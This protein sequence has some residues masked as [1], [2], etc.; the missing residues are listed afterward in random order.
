M[1]FKLHISDS[2]HP[3]CTTG[4]RLP[5]EL[6]LVKPPFGNLIEFRLE[7]IA[8]LYMYM[9][10]HAGEYRIPFC[11]RHS[12]VRISA[13]VY[14]LRGRSRIPTSQ[15]PTT[16]TLEISHSV[17]CEDRLHC[18]FRI[19]F[20]IRARKKSR[21]QPVRLEHAFSL[22]ICTQ[23]DLSRVTVL[24]LIDNSDRSVQ[25][26]TTNNSAGHWIVRICKQKAPSGAP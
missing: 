22:T 19:R 5:S 18:V 8:I 7:A 3:W 24:E 9:G 21:A 1:Q 11:E 23:G 13:N 12:T 15:F 10:R 16:K 26:F 25:D 17:A 6:A 2:V 20:E 14:G 4:N